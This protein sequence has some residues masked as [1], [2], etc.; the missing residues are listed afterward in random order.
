M[1]PHACDQIEDIATL[2]ANQKNMAENIVEIKEDIKE[3]KDFMFKMDD[4][5][6]RK[7]DVKKLDDKFW[8]WTLAIISVL[9]ACLAYFLSQFFIIK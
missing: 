6:A 1:T 7:E 5:Y 9:L 8:Y 3:I 4:K 2:K